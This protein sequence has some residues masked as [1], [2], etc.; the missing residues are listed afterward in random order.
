MTLAETQPGQIE[1]ARCTGVDARWAEL[2]SRLWPD[3]EAAVHASELAFLLLQQRVVGLLALSGGRAV[4]FAEA[5]L[6]TDYVNG[7]D[8]RP[9]VFIEGLWVEPQHRR[10]GVA[11]ALVAAVEEWADELECREVASDVLV[12]NASSLAV[13]RAL[14]FEETERVVFFRKRSQKGDA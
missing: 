10:R 8:S 12:D 3:M 9:V 6:R 14:G 1:I 4:G 11:R 13:H 7:C 2:R 5:A